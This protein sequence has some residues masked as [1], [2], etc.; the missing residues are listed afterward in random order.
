MTL[1]PILISIPHGGTQI[2]P[3]V[4]S[5]LSLSHR[6]LFDDSDPYTSEIYT[7]A[8]LVQQQVE[9]EVFRAVLDL[10][11]APDDLPPENSDGCFKTETCVGVT[12]YNEGAYPDAALRANLLAHYYDPYHDA[13]TRGVRDGSVKFA[14]DCHS[15]A[16]V[17]PVYAPD[18]G[19]ERPLFCLGNGDNR[20]SSREAITAL[21]DTIASVFSLST[22]SIG[23]NKPFKGGYITRTHG[24]NPVPWI[25][26]EMNRSLYLKYPWF[27]NES[28]LVASE[29]LAFLNSKMRE[30]FATFSDIYLLA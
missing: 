9:A 12:V 25:Q 3:E 5:L 8:D 2:P 6:D 27:Q 19:M 29:R 14:F 24:N 22:S 20:Y 7:C 21:A 18:R 13:I 11:R 1:L 26:I 23:I 17:A 10:N 28:G 30:V 16:A 4:S 15:M